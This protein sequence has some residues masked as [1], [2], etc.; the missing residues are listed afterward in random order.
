MRRL[1]L[2]PLCLALLVITAPGTA[3]A[4]DL[5]IAVGLPVLKPLLAS[6]LPS[7]AQVSSL[8]EPG[9]VPELFE[10]S[11]RQMQAAAM[12]DGM[13]LMGFP[14]EKRWASLLEPERVLVLNREGEVYAHPWTDPLQLISM[15]D[16]LADW[17]ISLQ[18]ELS[19]TVRE[20]QREMK[21]RLEALHVRVGDIMGPHQGRAFLVFHPAWSAFATRYGL[22]QMAIEK[23]GH[24]P[25]SRYLAQ[26]LGQAGERGIRIVYRQPQ[27]DSRLADSV[28]RQLKASIRVVD[29]L[30]QDYFE[31]ILEF[32]QQLD[33]EFRQRG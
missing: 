7:D 19:T 14:A 20:R 27:E 25:D 2:I 26:L 28:A 18:P 10:S 12:A 33:Q 24:E 5:R 21:A 30:R 1:S 22:V 8:L 13:V 9:Q 11:P 16:S 3:R 31:L 4:A 17:I 29:P 32:A 23:D 6:L 15:T